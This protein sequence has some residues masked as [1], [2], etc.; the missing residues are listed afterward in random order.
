MEHKADQPAMTPDP[1]SVSPILNKMD[2][3]M[4]R[5]RGSALQEEDIPVLT[6]LAPT[7]VDE[8][9]PVLTEVVTPF[10]GGLS[11]GV[12]WDDMPAEPTFSGEDE[13]GLMFDPEDWL[14]SGNA[15]P[16][17]SI[18]VPPLRV[19]AAPAAV[20]ESAAE[21]AESLAVDVASMPEMDFSDKG[22]AV[23]GGVEIMAP[24]AAVTAPLLGELELN[25]DALAAEEVP[26]D[27]LSAAAL[28]PQDVSTQ[29]SVDSDLPVVSSLE[30]VTLTTF[31][32]PAE[33]ASEPL[34]L[35]SLAETLTEGDLSVEFDLTPFHEEEP[36]AAETMTQS[37]IEQLI[38]VVYSSIKSELPRE[39]EGMV[40]QRMALAMSGW[41]RTVQLN[42]RAEI[43][44][45][46][47][48]SLE[49]RVTQLVCQALDQRSVRELPPPEDV[50][51][52]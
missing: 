12:I 41:Y 52:D 44:A 15:A 13:A 4:A 35:D 11:P 32:P 28:M 38:S 42:M 47:T 17:V 30:H 22:Q 34:Q 49:A 31:E 8:E 33:I 29:A 14:A 3:L 50:V 6:E 25:L 18:A 2:A 39:I 37:G 36:V 10:D 45:E 27:S 7:A 21:V 23:T 19:A 51:S 16:A 43:T 48:A 9:I 40:R 20:V 26:V 1:D 5:H 24:V 46:V